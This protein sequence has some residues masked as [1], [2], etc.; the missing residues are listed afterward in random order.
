[1]LKTQYKLAKTKGI[2]E[3][4]C[5][6]VPVFRL[7]RFALYVVGVATSMG[8]ATL[9]MWMLEYQVPLDF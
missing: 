6:Q 3:K 2:R 1:M 7:N 9:Q 8:S 4:F 5:T